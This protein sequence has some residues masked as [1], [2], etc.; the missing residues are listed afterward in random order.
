M[1]SQLQRRFRPFIALLAACCSRALR[2]ETTA[3]SDMA[4]S[5]L[6]R[7]SDRMMMASMSTESILVSC[8]EHL[9]GLCRR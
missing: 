7:I 8:R 1:G 2:A 5:P 3:I 4:K 9:P 6:T